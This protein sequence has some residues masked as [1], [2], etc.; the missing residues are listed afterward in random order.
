MCG[1]DD[2][3]QTVL[4]TCRLCI[5]RDFTGSRSIP[6][7]AQRKQSPDTF[8]EGQSERPS[9]AAMTPTIE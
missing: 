1:D 9:E 8:V 3:R 6:I 7:C 2:K 4:H 5:A